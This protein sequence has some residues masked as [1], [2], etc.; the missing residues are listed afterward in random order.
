MT[1]DAAGLSL[2]EGMSLSGMTFGQLWLRQVAV[3]GDANA[4]EVEADV[5]GLLVPDPHQH[6]VI[7]Q[8]LNECFIDQG[9]DHPVHY[10]QI[11]WAD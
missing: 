6:N 7:A 11:H 4:M 3:G 1:D 5:L 2:E 10:R 8:A 9:N